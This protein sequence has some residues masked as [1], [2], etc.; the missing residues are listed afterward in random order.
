MVRQLLVDV[1]SLAQQFLAESLQFIGIQETRT[2]ALLSHWIAQY[3]AINSP[4]LATGCLGIDLWIHQSLKPHLSGLSCSMT[5]LAGF[6]SKS[7]CSAMLYT[8]CVGMRQIPDV[9]K[10]LVFGG[11]LRQRCCNKLTGQCPLS[12]LLHANARVASIVCSSIGSS[13]QISKMQQATSSISFSWLLTSAF[14]L[15]SIR[16]D[17][18]AHGVPAVA[19]SIA[20]A[21]FAVRHLGF[22]MLLE[23]LFF[24]HIVLSTSRRLEHVVADVTLKMLDAQLAAR[25]S[26]RPF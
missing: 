3:Y 5:S 6:L 19:N 24:T 16:Q 12:S 14:R 11:T 7:L 9:R 13:V 22:R 25:A 1:S 17:Q 10:T 20:S 18:R 4:T 8:I 15:H 26:A 23:P 2:H 21:T